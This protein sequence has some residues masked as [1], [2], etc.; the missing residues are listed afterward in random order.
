M[1]FM[2]SHMTICQ[3]SCSKKIYLKKDIVEYLKLFLSITF[4]TLMYA[5]KNGVE[6][7]GD[8]LMNDRLLV[9]PSFEESHS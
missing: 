6:L 1:N 8:W 7:P 3:K 4:P 2:T 5:E 9:F